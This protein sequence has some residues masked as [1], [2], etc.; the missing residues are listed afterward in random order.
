MRTCVECL[1][2]VP[3][4]VRQVSL[5]NRLPPLNTLLTVG[6]SQTSLDTSVA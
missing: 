5:V 4:G 2:L 1:L 6:V 3:I